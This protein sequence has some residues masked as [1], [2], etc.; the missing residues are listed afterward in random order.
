MA[1][2][3]LRPVHSPATISKGS[4]LPSISDLAQQLFPGR[5]GLTVEETG[6]VL[7]IGDELAYKAVHDGTLP[8]KRIGRR[9]IIP[10]A[11]LEAWL[12]S[13]DVV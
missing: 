10:I 12:S 7:G 11:T 6:R 2:T 9:I 13:P 4:A 3:E 1:L 5:L 8:A